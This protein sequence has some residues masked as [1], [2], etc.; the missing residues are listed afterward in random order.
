M[1]IQSYKINIKIYGIIREKIVTKK[2][3]LRYH[4]SIIY[5]RIVFSQKL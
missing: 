1:I 5:A 4:A 2:Q 3:Y